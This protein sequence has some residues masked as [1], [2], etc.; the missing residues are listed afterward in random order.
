[1]SL[2]AG[3][4]LALT[5]FSPEAGAGTPPKAVKGDRIDMRPIGADCSQRAW[6]YFETQCLRDRKQLGGQARQVRVVST[7]RSM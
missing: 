1:M 4:V 5:G 3:M 6:P 2:G 7:D